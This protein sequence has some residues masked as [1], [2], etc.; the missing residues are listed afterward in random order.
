MTTGKC[1]E[2]LGSQWWGDIHR[3]PCVRAWVYFLGV[4][5]AVHTSTQLDGVMSTAN[6]SHLLKV[7][8]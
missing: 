1:T 7:S 4:I 2:A 8:Q 5:P 6:P 3:G